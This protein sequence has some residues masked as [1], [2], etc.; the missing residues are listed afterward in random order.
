MSNQKE[1]NKFN[2]YIINRSI[3]SVGQ[4]SIEIYSAFLIHKKQ[5]QFH[6]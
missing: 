5:K 4:D 1:T 2:F 6:F 3:V